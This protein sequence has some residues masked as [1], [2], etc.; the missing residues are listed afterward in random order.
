MQNDINTTPPPTIPPG[1]SKGKVIAG[2][3][4]LMIGGILLLEQLGGLILPSW[5]ISWSSFLIVIGLY[6]G[7]KHNFRNPIAYILIVW[8]SFG[9]LDDI[10]PSIDFSRMF[11]PLVI[12]SIGILMIL[13]RNTPWGR[14]RWK[15]R[16]RRDRWNEGQNWAQ[17]QTW[18][19]SQYDWDKKVEPDN[20][21]GPVAEEPS[22]TYTNTGYAHSGHTYKGYPVEDYLDATSIFGSS[23][24]TIF[25]KT[26]RGGEIVNI[27]GGAEIDFTQSDINGQVIIDVTQIFGGIKL[28]VPPHWHV[29]SDT[30]SLF[31]GFDDKRKQK[32]NLTSDKILTITGTSIFAG[33]E[34]R[35]Y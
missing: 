7:A 34:I 6:T 23:T 4:L 2:F 5:V 29:T 28:L 13:K 14:G 8:G 31:A 20:T 21:T 24:K 17:N 35:S 22:G 15:R 32:N 33:I 27:F 3:I 26:F 11:W 19:K 18:A 10:F 16:K 12:I 25:T 1:Q 9:L 30:V